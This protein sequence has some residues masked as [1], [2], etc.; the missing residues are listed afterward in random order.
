MTTGTHPDHLKK[1]HWNKKRVLV[2]FCFWLRE[3][4]TH[5]KE[6][7]ETGLSLAL[8]FSLRLLTSSLIEELK[9][10]SAIL[11]ILAAIVVALAAELEKQ[12]TVGCSTGDFEPTG[13]KVITLEPLGT[14][15]CDVAKVNIRHLEI[16]ESLEAGKVIATTFSHGERHVLHA[17]RCCSKCELRGLEDVLLMPMKG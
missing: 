4:S 15:S 12:L 10:P 17:R 1:V 8:V 9:W 6:I 14:L 11:A 13:W 2:V 7:L 16:N 3:I 5:P